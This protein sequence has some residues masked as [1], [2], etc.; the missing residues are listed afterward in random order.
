MARTRKV[1]PAQRRAL[2]WLADHDGE[3]KV[4]L[5]D[6]SPQTLHNLIY[7]RLITAKYATVWGSGHRPIE[8]VRITAAGRAA[9]G[10]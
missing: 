9:V 2:L 3:Q 10:K 4:S 7:D 8:T 5:L 6:V 1:T